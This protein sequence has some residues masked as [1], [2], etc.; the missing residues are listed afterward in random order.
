MSA[1]IALFKA[2]GHLVEGFLRVRLI[3][4]G[5]CFVGMAV[6]F[7]VC[8]KAKLSNVKKVTGY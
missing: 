3:N 7:F 5:F 1:L 8:K 6:F 2:A 4:R